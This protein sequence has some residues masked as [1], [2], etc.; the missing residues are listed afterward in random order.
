[1][2][3]LANDKIKKRKKIIDFL[4][5]KEKKE[6]YGIVPGYFLLVFNRGA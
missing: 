3:S 2:F 1:M 6:K 5:T 4:K